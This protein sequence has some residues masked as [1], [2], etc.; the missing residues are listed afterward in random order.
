MLT[1]LE[2]IIRQCSRSIRG[3][4]PAILLFRVNSA[5]NGSAK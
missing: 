3:L 1:Q 5:P 2:V 4:L